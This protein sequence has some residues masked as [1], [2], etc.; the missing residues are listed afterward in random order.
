MDD[1]WGYPHFR[2]PQD[3][4]KLFVYP[5]STKI[6][7]SE[8]KHADFWQI[9]LLG[10]LC[11][12]RGEKSHPSQVKLGLLAAI[13]SPSATLVMTNPWNILNHSESYWKNMLNNFL[14]T[15]FGTVWQSKHFRVWPFVC[16]TLSLQSECCE[17]LARVKAIFRP[18]NSW[19]ILRG[20]TVSLI[21]QLQCLKAI[22][23]SCTA[24][25][26]HG[27]SRCAST[28][29]ICNLQCMQWICLTI[30]VTHSNHW[31]LIFLPKWQ[32]VSFR[33]ILPAKNHQKSY[34]N[35]TKNPAS[36]G[37]GWPGRCPPG[38]HPSRPEARPQVKMG[39]VLSVEI[40]DSI[41][42]ANKQI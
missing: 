1:N 10:L 17:Q 8:G 13:P 34:E 22:P 21:F 31:F 4:W 35:P 14:E 7:L 37:M 27:L 25:V 23:K 33:P 15:I 16:A 5:P 6:Q 29:K 18:R 36:I 42:A 11:I 24:A 41:L 9:R 38:L 39:H 30:G 40:D 19:V 3:L 28:G 12:L 2:K 20:T 32:F 26:Y